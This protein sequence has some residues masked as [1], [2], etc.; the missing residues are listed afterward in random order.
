MP[1][2]GQRMAL[3]LGSV[4]DGCW[5]GQV[6]IAERSG[7]HQIVMLVMVQNSEGGIKYLVEQT[8]GLEMPQALLSRTGARYIRASDAKAN[9]QTGAPI[10]G[11]GT[12]TADPV[13]GKAAKLAWPQAVLGALA[14]NI[15][16]AV[17]FGVFIVLSRRAMGEGRGDRSRIFGP[18]AT[19]VDARSSE[20]VKMAMV[21]AGMIDAEG[22]PCA[23]TCPGAGQ[24]RGSA[25]H[26]EPGA[27][28]EGTN[29]PEL[30]GTRG[31]EKTFVLDPNVP[32]EEMSSEQIL[33]AFELTVDEVESAGKM[34]VR[35]A[36]KSDDSAT[37]VAETP[38]GD[39][40]GQSAAE[41]EAEPDLKNLSF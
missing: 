33:K 11:G 30:D 24:R 20:G 14:L 26:A 19:A 2:S 9:T 25:G 5:A 21:E 31:G 13:S 29:Q 32:F 4:E 40:N 1:P 10:G 6:A 41:A 39:S 34:L 15:G 3:R 8:Y 16:A 35:K 23:Q 17:I 7:L 28:A 18:K 37:A 36:E 12:T 38:G 22:R 27:T